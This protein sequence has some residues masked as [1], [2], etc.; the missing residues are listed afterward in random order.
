MQ[1]AVSQLQETHPQIL[2]GSSPGGHEAQLGWWQDKAAIPGLHRWRVLPHACPSPAII[3]F[4]PWSSRDATHIQMCGTAATTTVTLSV[5][6][7]AGAH[8]PAATWGVCVKCPTPPPLRSLPATCF[9]KIRQQS[10]CGSRVGWCLTPNTR[11]LVEI[12]PRALRQ[13]DNCDNETQ[14]SQG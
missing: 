12:F 9:T 8:S 4:N 7:S 5:S 13:A 1:K 11:R 6:R 10:G 14:Y 2:Q 3:F